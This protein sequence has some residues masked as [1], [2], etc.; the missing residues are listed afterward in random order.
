MAD[1]EN[2]G[3]GED[4]LQRESEAEI[5]EVEA[6]RGPGR[7]PGYPKTGGRVRDPIA[8]G[9]MKHLVKIAS[10]EKIMTSG[11]TGKEVGKYPSLSEQLRAAE[12]IAAITADTKAE[13]KEAPAPVAEPEPSYDS[14][15][16]RKAIAEDYLSRNPSPKPPKPEADEN[17]IISVTDPAEIAKF[18]AEIAS[19]S[20]ITSDSHS[21]TIPNG[22]SWQR[23][24]DAM[25]Q[26]DIWNLYDPSGRHSG[27]RRT[28][29]KADAWCE[30]EGVC[31]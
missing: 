21:K 4:E 22:F 14:E 3:P 18:D 6:K 23:T 12:I 7:P 20:S 29:E 8:P 26:R 19:K 11:P 15:A 2:D 9:F 25:T 10:G 30:L 5:V 28:Q 1:I 17:G 24:Y 13:V 31:T 16:L 27:V